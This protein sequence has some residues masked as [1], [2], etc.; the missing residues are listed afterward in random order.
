MKELSTQVILENKGF[1]D[2]A[3]DMSVQTLQI[4]EENPASSGAESASANEPDNKDVDSCE[5]FRKIVSSPIDDYI[6]ITK[7]HAT[8]M[9]KAHKA[10]ST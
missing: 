2:V 3:V 6:S 1:Q 4:K 8:K 5:I 9:K 10:A 7:M